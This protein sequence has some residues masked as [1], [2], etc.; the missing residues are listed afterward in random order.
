[1]AQLQAFQRLIDDK[2]DEG[3][4]CILQERVPITCVGSPT[5]YNYKCY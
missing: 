5:L 2:A 3:K 4:R 1:M